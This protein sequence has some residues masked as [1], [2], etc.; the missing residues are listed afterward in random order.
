MLLRLVPGHIVEAQLKY[1][2]Q[3][4]YV[5]EEALESYQGEVEHFRQVRKRRVMRIAQTGKFLY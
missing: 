2:R 4:N 1:F 5:S 3:K